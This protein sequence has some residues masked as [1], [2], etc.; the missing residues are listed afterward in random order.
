MSCWEIL[1]IM[2]TADE[3]AIRRAY[4][5]KLKVT[6]PDE[7]P[8]GYQALR[9]ALEEA[10]Q[11]APYYQET[12]QEEEEFSPFEEPAPENA[13]EAEKSEE[14]AVNFSNEF[15]EAP[16]KEIQPYVPEAEQEEQEYQFEIQENH[17]TEYSEPDYSESDALLN[18]IHRIATNEGEVELEKQWRNLYFELTQLPLEQTDYVSWQVWHLFQALRIENPFVWA[19]WAGYFDWHND[20]RF[21][22]HCDLDWLDYV[23][24]RINFA[25]Q[26]NQVSSDDVKSNSTP[27]LTAVYDRLS[28]G[29]SYFLTLF[30][31]VLISPF[32]KS[33]MNKNPQEYKHVTKLLPQQLDNLFS[34]VKILRLSFFVGII[35]LSYPLFIND[36]MNINVSKSIVFIILL[37]PFNFIV[38]RFIVPII[39]T[40]KSIF[41][42]S[43][44]NLTKKKAVIEGIIPLLLII[45][46]AIITPEYIYSSR[47]YLLTLIVIAWSMSTFYITDDA[48]LW[49]TYFIPLFIGAFLLLELNIDLHG[50]AFLIL[51]AL[52][53][54]I[55][56]N[57]Y[58]VHFEFDW[59]SK[60]HNINSSIWQERELPSGKNILKLPL[61]GIS[62][63]IYWTFFLPFH[64]A[65]LYFNLRTILVFLETI[66]SA[67]VLTIF[68]T[69]ILNSR[70]SFII[71][72]ASLYFMVVIQFNIKNW[73]FKRLKIENN[74]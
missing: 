62:S 8:V 37:I 22:Q 66:I 32:L 33:E 12:E 9:E 26:L 14:S 63:F 23:R 58:I 69:H 24:E 10:L 64:I 60:L 65:R 31:L 41:I 68:L 74:T 71:F 55:Q 44:L 54:W 43:L 19:Q 70:F 52:V 34:F 38:M 20:Y 35:A 36:I 40:A 6:R 29:Y 30:Y 53:L 16:Q 50:N 56:F 72:C 17:E 3:R 57:L 25:N 49:H 48:S 46:L 47:F 73:V 15:S 18:E 42:P 11:L 28:N 67:S 1:E 27:I 51:S 2:P 61:Y 21:A 39:I 13:L 5:K 7:D 45:L 59:V 4:A